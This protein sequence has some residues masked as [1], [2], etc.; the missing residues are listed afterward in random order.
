MYNLK[1][2][3]AIP[4]KYVFIENSYLPYFC[5]HKLG[6]VLKITFEENHLQ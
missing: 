1:E 4:Q 3:N 5:N 2:K 6:K